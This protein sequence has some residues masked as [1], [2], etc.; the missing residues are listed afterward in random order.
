MREPLTALAP[1]PSE[2]T[3]PHERGLRARLARKMDGL[4]LPL[5]ATPMAIASLAMLII[6]NYDHRF[7]RGDLRWTLLIF[8]SL[9]VLLIA[10]YVALARGDRRLVPARR[11]KFTLALL[12]FLAGNTILQVSLILPD[13]N[14][15]NRYGVDAAAA[16]DCATQQFM[17]GHDP[18]A[19]VHMLTCLATHGLQ[20][21]QT[22]PKSA[23]RFWPFATFPTRNHPEFQ[24]GT[25]SFDNL[26][27]NTYWRDL[28][29]EQQDPNYAPAEF[30]TRFNY[31]GA[32]IFFGWAAWV[33]GARDLVGLF[34]ACVIL[35][36]WLIYRQTD[37]RARLAT[38]LLLVGNTPLILD[39]A[40]GATDILYATLLVIYWQVR[41][42]PLV[43]GLVLGLAAATRQQVW[44]FVPFLLF[45]A[46]RWHG[47]H[48]LWR[49]SSVALAVFIGC[50][51]P[52]ILMGP[53]NWLAGVLGPMTDPLFAQ[54]IG[55][56]ALTI[57]LFQQHIGPSSLY[58]VLEGVALVGCFWLYTRHWQRAPGLAMMLPL[59]PLAL[60]WRSLHTYFM[61]LPLLAIAVL[62]CPPTI[63]KRPGSTRRDLASVEPLSGS[64]A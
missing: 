24:V 36:S 44:F 50:N 43:G 10:L 20:F 6:R 14:Q 53:Q 29:R 30:E 21:N 37:R 58:A 17:R 63:W 34:L 56:I 33:F 7:I 57:A 27:W 39:S 16:T 61:V 11:R 55:L 2:A 3:E 46:W 15:V 47:W 31:P 35:A 52:F 5:W 54:G 19:N 9:V 4:V 12:V 13:L 18:Y 23:G 25:S 49:R 1:F 41:E 40:V 32:A 62:A 51:L 59:I 45:L 8:T 38:G 48:D 22:T 26:L 42:R 60:A 28:K 64:S